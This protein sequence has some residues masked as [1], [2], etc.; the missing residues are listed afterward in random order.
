MRAS[1][2]VLQMELKVY[3]AKEAKV[4]IH[5]GGGGRRRREEEEGFGD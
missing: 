5:H 1:V 2:F 3:V 4:D